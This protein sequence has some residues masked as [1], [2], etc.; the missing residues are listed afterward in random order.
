MKAI[1]VLLA[2][3]VISGF[4]AS[5]SSSDDGDSTGGDLTARWNETKTVQKISG[6]TY[7]YPYTGNNPS[8]DKDYIEFTDGGSFNRA[9][10]NQDIHNV[11]IESAD[12]VYE[13]QKTDNTLAISGGD[14]GGTYEIK[15]LTDSQLT[16]QKEE[17]TGSVTT[18]FIIYFTK[19]AGSN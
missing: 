7:N 17:T 14:Y 12:N 18:T 9:I 16:I 10:F 4:A 3:L 1:K 8:C 15:K 19:A 6:E 5:C 2:A 13:W 11:C